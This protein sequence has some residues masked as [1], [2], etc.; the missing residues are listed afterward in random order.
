MNTLIW[1]ETKHGL[2]TYPDGWF[3]IGQWFIEKFEGKC[4][5]TPLREVNP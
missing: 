2:R 3:R 5:V 1:A 4:L